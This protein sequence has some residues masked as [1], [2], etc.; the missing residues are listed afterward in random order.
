MDFIP[1]EMNAQADRSVSADRADRI[2]TWAQV[3]PQ[4]RGR[5]SSLSG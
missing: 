2:A 5:L 4:R 1:D 3:D